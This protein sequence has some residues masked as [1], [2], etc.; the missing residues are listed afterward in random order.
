MNEFIVWDKKRKE[1]LH[2]EKHSIHLF[3]ETIIMGELLRRKDD[4]HVRLEDLNDIEAFN[5][6]GKT[7]IEGN[8]IYADC[9]IVSFEWV[10]SEKEIHY[11]LGYFRWNK[12]YLSYFIWDGVQEWS[13]RDILSLEVKG[14]LQED[15]LLLKKD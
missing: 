4:S 5:Y 8:K 10:N 2:D 15:K 6:I 14:T 3:G 12:D 9:S 13:I 1:W 11:D 7:D